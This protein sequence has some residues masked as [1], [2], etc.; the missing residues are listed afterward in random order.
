MDD[1]LE[2]EMAGARQRF[3]RDMQPVKEALA[4]SKSAERANQEKIEEIIESVSSGRAKGALFDILS[5]RAPEL[6][7]E[8][9]KL[10]AEQRRLNELLVTCSQQITSFTCRVLRLQ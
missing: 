8:R 4:L 10:R 3:E 1:L 6:K 5:E 7:M 9:E 2:R